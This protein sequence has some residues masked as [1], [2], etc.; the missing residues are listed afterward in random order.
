MSE[1]LT[2]PL[3]VRMVISFGGL[4]NLI[5]SQRFMSDSAKLVLE[6]SA[7]FEFNISELVDAATPR[8]GA[9]YYIKKTDLDRL[10]TFID[11]YCVH[12]SIS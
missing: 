8:T 5:L 10:D 6:F 4:T 7:E 1:L 11:T 2:L 9:I 3:W 12:C